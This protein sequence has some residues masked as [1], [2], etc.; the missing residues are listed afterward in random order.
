MN[1]KYGN[2]MFIIFDENNGEQYSKIFLNTLKFLNYW[3][4]FIKSQQEDGIFD[5][6]N[7]IT[8]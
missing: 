7:F 2:S 4:T 1:R 5:D 3:Y 8:M 6:K